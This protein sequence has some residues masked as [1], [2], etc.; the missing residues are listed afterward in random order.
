MS[1][2][3]S[4]LARLFAVLGLINIFFMHVVTARLSSRKSGHSSTSYKAPVQPTAPNGLDCSKYYSNLSTKCTVPQV[5][6]TIKISSPTTV[7]AGET[8][9]CKLAKYQHTDTTCDLDKEKGHADAVFLLEDGAT[10]KN[11]HLGYSQESRY[12]SSSNLF[13]LPCLLSKL[14]GLSSCRIHLSQV[15]IVTESAR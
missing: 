2:T 13:P 3:F 15:C 7:A 6:Q 8:F 4:S 11:C 9:D 14:V 1:L 12:S 10:L 5:A